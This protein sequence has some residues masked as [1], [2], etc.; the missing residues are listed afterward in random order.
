MMRR[1]H[2]ICVTESIL[3]LCNVLGVDEDVS[4][5][6]VVALG[7]GDSST[8]T[9]RNNDLDWSELMKCLEAIECNFLGVSRALTRSKSNR[10]WVA[11]YRPD[12][13]TRNLVWELVKGLGKITPPDECIVPFKRIKEATFAA[14]FQGDYLIEQRKRSSFKQTL[15]KHFPYP[16]AWDASLGWL[17]VSLGT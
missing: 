13:R 4:N 10:A 14:L 15:L 12:W 17:A 8:D 5:P 16:N 7:D 3:A 2:S 9:D 11:D 1:V 6:V